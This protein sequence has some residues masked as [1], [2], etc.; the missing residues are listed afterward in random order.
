MSECFPG[1]GDEG[2]CDVYIL[3]SCSGCLSSGARPVMGALL[4]SQDKA[5]EVFKG[6]DVNAMDLL[7]TEGFLALAMVWVMGIK[8]K[9]SVFL[10]PSYRIF[11][12]GRSNRGSF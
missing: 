2:L 7:L 9:G 11:Q 4:E 12:E 10:Y 5:S 8:R 3:R 1:S 6:R